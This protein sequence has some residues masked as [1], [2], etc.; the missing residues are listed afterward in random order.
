MMRV[1]IPTNPRTMASIGVR[2]RWEER[3]FLR[4]LLCVADCV[5]EDIDFDLGGDAA[6]PDET[7]DPAVLRD[8]TFRCCIF[9]CRYFLLLYD[10]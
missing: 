6:A 10:R 3:A 5:E 1:R 9:V 4:A 7:A 2:L 8:F